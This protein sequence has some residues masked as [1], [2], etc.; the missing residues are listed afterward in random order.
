MIEEL[1]QNK[2]WIKQMIQ[3]CKQKRESKAIE[4]NHWTRKQKNVRGF[5]AAENLCMT[6]SNTMIEEN[7][8]KIVSKIKINDENQKN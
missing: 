8:K 2:P 5:S 7:K 3:P 1:S 4:S 6:A